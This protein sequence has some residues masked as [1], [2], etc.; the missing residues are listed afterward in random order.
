MRP[1]ARS[2][3]A[4]LVLTFA[5]TVVGCGGSSSPANGAFSPR[6]FAAQAN[7]PRSGDATA[8]SATATTA[9]TTASP[10]SAP[11]ATTTPPAAAP[12]GTGAAAPEKV[13]AEPPKKIGARHVLVQWMG[14]DRAGKSVLRT[15]EQAQVIA[16]EVL[17]RAKGGED[18]GR[19]AVD[20]SDEPNAG[21]RGGSL[22]RF[23]RGQMVPA[24]EQVAFRLK[25]GQLSEIVETPFGF[26]IIQRTE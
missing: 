18:L 11:K 21:P 12:A 19:L 9:S 16:E 3:L 8:S 14:S 26:H 4:A 24:F 13:E 25:V 2:V 1:P 23:T 20:Y 10:A 22:G 7:D 6:P 15:R 5:V 17:K